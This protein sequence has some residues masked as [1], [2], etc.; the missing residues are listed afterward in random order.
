MEPSGLSLQHLVQQ[1]WKYHH[2]TFDLYLC[3]GGVAWT[4]AKMEQVLLPEL[5]RLAAT[6]LS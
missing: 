1:G 5:S 2:A 4:A 6:G 3:L